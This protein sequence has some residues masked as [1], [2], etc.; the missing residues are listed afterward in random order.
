MGRGSAYQRLHGNF[1]EREEV[2]QLYQQFAMRIRKTKMSSVNLAN[3]KA[4]DNIMRVVTIEVWGKG[5]GS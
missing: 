3:I 5:H 1:R 2:S 4:T